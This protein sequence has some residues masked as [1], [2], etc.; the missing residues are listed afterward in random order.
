MFLND[1]S[2]KNCQQNVEQKYGNGQRQTD[3]KEISK[4]QVF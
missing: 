1:I 3:E 2:W 4:S